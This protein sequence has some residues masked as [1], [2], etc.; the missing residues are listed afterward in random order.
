MSQFLRCGHKAPQEPLILIPKPVRYFCAECGALI[1]LAA[2]GGTGKPRGRPKKV[3][4]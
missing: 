4:A 3:A 1:P 2:K